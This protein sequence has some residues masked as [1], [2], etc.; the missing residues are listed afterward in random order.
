M[1]TG[2]YANAKKQLISLILL[3]Q[4]IKEAYAVD[5]TDSVPTLKLEDGEM[6][7]FMAKIGR[8]E[9]AILCLQETVNKVYKCM[10]EGI[11]ATRTPDEMLA[12]LEMPSVNSTRRAAVIGQNTTF[13]PAR[14]SNNMHSQHQRSTT[15]STPSASATQIQPTSAGP[16][17][18][19]VNIESTSTRSAG[20]SC[21]V[22][23]VGGSDYRWA[24]CQP[25]VSATSASSAASS[26]VETDDTAE[27]RDDDDDDFTL[28][29]NRR[30]K[31]RRR[32]SPTEATSGPRPGVSTTAAASGQTVTG[33]VPS[34][35]AAAKKPP[36]KPLVVG[37]IRSPG[38]VL[39]SVTVQPGSTTQLAKRLTAT[40]PLYGKAVFC[41]DNLHKDITVPDLE[42]Y[43]KGI[44][45]RVLGCDETKPRRSYRQKV[46][47]V[48]PDDRKAFRLCINKADTKLLLNP[49]KWPADVSVSAW[50]FRKKD[51]NIVNN[52]HTTSSLPTAAAAAAVVVAAATPPLPPSPPSPPVAVQTDRDVTAAAVANTATVTVD[53]HQPASS[54]S[55]AGEMETDDAETMNLSP[56]DS[57]HNTGHSDEFDEA[58]DTLLVNNAHNSTSIH[59][60][61]LSSI[62]QP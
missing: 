53:V 10:Y 43:V 20:V 25:S 13:T 52:Q 38:P 48:V 15:V 17:N 29:E 9:D 19:I 51:D 16:Q 33:K 8:L 27:G 11:K 54:V 2:M 12:M 14:Q 4:L 32:R 35:A 41:I 62:V 1:A 42:Q 59:V 44:G 28:V 24:D 47:N 26:A 56:I 57:L 40:K 3:L 22:G 34:F 18:A 58:S 21:G 36:R 55:P 50:F 30:T 31:R 37:T 60:V 7:Y 45:V 46:N 5:N 39:T 49:S 6:H 61:D 23:G